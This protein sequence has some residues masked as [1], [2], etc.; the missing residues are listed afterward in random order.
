[1]KI[2]L[3]GNPK[4]IYIKHYVKY[5][6]HDELSKIYLTCN[7][8]L[9]YESK[10]F[11][12][13][14]N[15]NLINL[16]LKRGFLKNIPKL[17]TFTSLLINLGEYTRNGRFDYIHIH[18]VGNNSLMR[19]ISPFLKR[20][21]K[22]VILTFWGSDILDINKKQ[23]DLL[24]GVLNLSEKIVLSTAMMKKQFRAYYG[25]KYDHKIIQC[26]FGNTLISRVVE[27][28]QNNRQI[29]DSISSLENEIISMDSSFLPLPKD[30]Y[31]ISI[32]YSGSSRQ[33]HKLVLEEIKD[34]PENIK[35][36]I[37]CVIQMSYGNI[38]QKYQ[39]DIFSLMQNYEIKGNIITKWLSPEETL[40]F[41]LQV[42]LFI[43]AQISD[44]LSASVL[45]YLYLDRLVFNPSWIKYVEWEE[46]GCKYI[47][48]DSFAELPQLITEAMQGRFNNINNDVQS[49]IEE[50]FSWQHLSNCWQSLYN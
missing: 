31:I 28:K 17:A 50:R 35:K 7:E 5:V 6:L 2:L 24:V 26:F 36:N 23:A 42:D 9:D 4:S 20:Y 34:L 18:F 48:Y 10:K 11:Y 44:A 46:L 1:M 41:K 29:N 37:Y 49:I 40:Y 14:H 30:K 33:Q 25:Q 43:H 47:E 15:V 45:E 12:Q 21:C 16:F 39:A 3:W 22:K 13:A 32:G 8:K 38:G 27:L 19:Y